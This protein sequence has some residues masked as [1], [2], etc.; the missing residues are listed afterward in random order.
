MIHAFISRR[1]LKFMLPLAAGGVVAGAALWISTGSGERHANPAFQEAG[2]G[3]RIDRAEVVRIEPFASAIPGDAAVYDRELHLVGAG[4]Q[5][6]SFGPFVSFETPA[7]SVE[8]RAVELLSEGEVMAY[9]PA[10]LA[11]SLRVWVTN[12]DQRAAR[13]DVQL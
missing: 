7:G 11:G 8:A 6:T 4:F 10:G 3:P 5:G 9:V 1:A 12:S 13:F 2:A